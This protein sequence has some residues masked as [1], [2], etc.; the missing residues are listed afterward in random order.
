MPLLLIGLIAAIGAK[1]FGLSTAIAGFILVAVAAPGPDGPS[2]SFLKS[3]TSI[4][5][6]PVIDYALSDDFEFILRAGSYLLRL[7]AK[8]SKKPSPPAPPSPPIAFN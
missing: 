6:Q 5:T 4:W 8:S 1:P 2:F 7:W 3:I